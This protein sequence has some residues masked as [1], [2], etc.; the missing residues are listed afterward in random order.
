MCKQHTKPCAQCPWRRTSLA[1]WLGDSTPQ[2]FMAQADSDTRMPCHIHIDYERDDWQEQV[3]RGP[4][5]AGHAIFL[6]N[7]C[8]LPYDP[9]LRAFVATVLQDPQTVFQWP[10]EFIEHH[11]TLKIKV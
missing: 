10:H 1:G 7:R 2:E 5:C 3:E 11:S 6:K 8:K 4:R 9:G